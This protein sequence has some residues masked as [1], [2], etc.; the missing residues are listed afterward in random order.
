MPAEPP[1]SGLRL[2][3]GLMVMGSEMAGFTVIGVVLDL[4][5]GTMPWLTITLTLLG[6]AFVFFHLMRYSKSMS[7]RNGKS[8]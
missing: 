8:P 7:G 5:L 4:A 3:V 6:F 2:S 1:P